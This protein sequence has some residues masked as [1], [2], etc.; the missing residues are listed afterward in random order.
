MKDVQS[1]TKVVF[2][3]FRAKSQVWH[4]ATNRRSPIYSNYIL[5][6]VWFLYLCMH[7]MHMFRAQHQDGPSSPGSSASIFTTLSGNDIFAY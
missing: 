7:P 3:D 5:H 6:F 4:K 2:G 1:A